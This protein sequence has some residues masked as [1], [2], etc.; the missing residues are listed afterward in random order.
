M[1]KENKRGEGEKEFDAKDVWDML[2]STYIHNNKLDIV[3]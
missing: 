1:E 2:P 3:N